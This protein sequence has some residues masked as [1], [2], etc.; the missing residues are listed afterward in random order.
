MFMQCRVTS[1]TI[2][3]LRSTTREE[4]VEESLEVMEEVEDL[5]E[6]VDILFATIVDNRDTTHET[7]PTLPLPISIA[8]L[9]I[10]I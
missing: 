6:V 1:R 3:A 8:S 4:K 2:L 9:T 10:I 5:V 7:V